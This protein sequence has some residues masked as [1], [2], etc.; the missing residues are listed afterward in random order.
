MKNR[1]APFLFLFL[2]VALSAQNPVIVLAAD[3]PAPELR[4]AEV[5]QFYLG[6]MTG[7]RVPIQSKKPRRHSSPVFIGQHKAAGRYGLQAPP[8]RGEDAYF[9]QG[10]NGAFQLG[11]GGESGPEYAAYSLL[12]MLGGR[13]YS[14]LD[15]CI[16]EM[17]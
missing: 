9:L 11:G 6:K 12:E 1:L 7:Q 16:P 5:L 15:S 8:P 14:P 13:L 3:A 2:P 17:K 10:K 4:A